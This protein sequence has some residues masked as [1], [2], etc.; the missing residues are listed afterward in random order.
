M[1]KKVTIYGERC[2]GTNYLE[3]LLLLNFDVEIIWSYGWKHFFGF[4]DLKY[5]DDV[6]FIGIIRNLEDW[7]N[8]LYREKHHFPEELNQIDAYLNNIF[9]SIDGNKEIMNDRN[10]ETKERYK[11]IFELRHIKNKFLIE[12]MPTLVKNYCLIRYDDLINNF[13]NTMNKIKNY[14]LK[15]NENNI[16]FPLNIHYYKKEKD[17]IYQKTP[18][19]ISKEIIM[20]KANLYYEKMLFKNLDF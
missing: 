2:S 4:H 11:N 7:I 20:K 10:I 6:L 5:S 18:N 9:Y 13:V 1:L 8:S 14:N 17:K 19:K 15:I 12:T 3:E 16:K